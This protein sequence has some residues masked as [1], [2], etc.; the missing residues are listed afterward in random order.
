MNPVKSGWLPAIFSDSI[1][2]SS[3]IISFMRAIS[4]G[5][6]LAIWS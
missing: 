6:M 3:R 1:W 4:S 5:L 2:F